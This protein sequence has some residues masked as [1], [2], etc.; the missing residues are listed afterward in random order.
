MCSSDLEVDPLVEQSIQQ[1][2][3]RK[4][5]ISRTGQAG[6]L[7]RMAAALGKSGVGESDRWAGMYG[8]AAEGGER[9]QAALN[10]ADESIMKAKIAGATARQARK[11]GMVDK[12][13]AA[14]ETAEKYRMEGKHY[15]QQARTS[16]A[17]VLGH[18]R[19]TDVH[20]AAQ[21]AAAN[22]PGETE[23]M[24]AEI[25]AIRSGKSTFAGL[26]GE[27]G[28]A[29]YTGALGD[30]DRKSTRLNSSH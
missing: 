21:Y 2:E 26:S 29:A 8:A 10:A 24:L 22:R 3:A 7:L 1:Q 20:A 12:A 18:M 27:E 11:D 17:Q 19:D 28:V 4:A 13:T 14:E 15:Q 5:D 25:N 6:T 30:V 16:A 9:M 23:R